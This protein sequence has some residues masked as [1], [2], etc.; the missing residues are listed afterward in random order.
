MARA[1]PARSIRLVRAPGAGAASVGVLQIT[2]GKQSQFYAFVEI[3][4]EIGGRGF[5]IHRLGL[6]DAYDVRVGRPADCS[7]ECMGWLRHAHCKH[8]HGL[9]ALLKSR[10]L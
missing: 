10:Q 9:R 1:K 8:V 4:C 7:C 6:G 2:V 3:R 5:H